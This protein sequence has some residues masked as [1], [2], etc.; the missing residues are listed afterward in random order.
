MHF[1]CQVSLKLQ[2][3]YLIYS[4]KFIGSHPHNWKQLVKITLT[5]ID[6][7]TA[8]LLTNVDYIAK[9]RRNDSTLNI[10]N[11]PVQKFYEHKLSTRDHNQIN[12]IRS[13]TT[14]SPTKPLIP[15]EDEKRSKILMAVKEKL[16]RN[17]LFAFLFG[18]QE[19]GKLNFLLSQNAQVIVWLMQG[20]S[21]LVAR[22]LDEDNYGVV[23]Y[24]V[25]AILKSFIKL[26]AALEKVS[27]INTIAKDR[28]LYALKA[29]IRR[30]L[31]RITTSF[32]PYFED[33]LIDAE[34][35][36]ALHGF[37]IFKEL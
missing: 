16:L 34:D 24:D 19:S 7:F 36:R 27:A 31:Y 25:K 8:D 21:A 14:A 11:H 2:T 18:E 23:Q 20:I 5:L 33:M 10:L 30:S 28:N 17:K 22:S 26:K 6:K 15:S 1:Q 9:N 13:L 29:A 35:V 4:I 3:I 37:I 12:R 32:S